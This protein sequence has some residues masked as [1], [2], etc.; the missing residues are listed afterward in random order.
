MYAQ[1]KAA[2]RPRENAL[3]I[4]QLNKAGLVDAVECLPGKPALVLA[5]GGAAVV[6]LAG[7]GVDHAAAPHAV[8]FDVGDLVDVEQRDAAVAAHSDAVQQ[9]R[10][11]N[12]RC[13]GSRAA[14]QCLTDAVGVE[15]LEQIIVR[16]QLECAHGVFGIGR[17]KDDPRGRHQAASQRGDRRALH[18]T[19]VDIEKENVKALL[20]QQFD[21]LCAASGLNDLGIRQKLTNLVDQRNARVLFVVDHSDTH[22]IISL[23]TISGICGEM[24]GM[25]KATV[26]PCSLLS[27]VKTHCSP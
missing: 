24:S 3:D 15:G 6:G 8:C 27:M 1:G 19:E 10:W 4:A 22:K 18:I 25:E 23:Q 2:A 7:G 12:R 21:R 26:E 5:E 16:A 11:G 17:C 20:F 13:G 9:R 14:L